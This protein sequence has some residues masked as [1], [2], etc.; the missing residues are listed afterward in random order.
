MK[1]TA[2]IETSCEFVESENRFME[3]FYAG[4]AEAFENLHALFYRRLVRRA[5]SR[6]PS[7]LPARQEL[8]EDLVG[9][10]F[11]KV[12]RT[13]QRPLTRWEASKGPVRKWLASIL[14]KQIISFMRAKRGKE[15]ATTDVSARDE[16]GAPLYLEMQVASQQAD[17]EQTFFERLRR[18]EI[19]AAIRTLPDQTQAVLHL[20]Y[21]CDEPYREIGR[22]MGVSVPT[23]SR[24]VQQ[25]QDQLR[26]MLECEVPDF[27]EIQELF[28]NVAP[29]RSQA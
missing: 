23:I 6:L 17:A 27:S 11:A 13:R 5:A 25:A 3:R 29:Q 28:G 2:T 15:R 1:A 10:V 19:T 26:Q 22:R 14:H 20:K 4:D 8:A 24:R 21:W 12:L 18:R 16:S 9:E 7:R